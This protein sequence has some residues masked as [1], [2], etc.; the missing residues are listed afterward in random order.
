MGFCVTVMSVAD[1]LKM[2]QMEQKDGKPHEQDLLVFSL[3]SCIYL[4][5]LCSFVHLEDKT[6]SFVFL[7]LADKLKM[8]Q[9]E[10]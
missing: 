10:Q 2:K 9:M 5:L 8:K 7:E 3:F 1:K 4:S 6:P